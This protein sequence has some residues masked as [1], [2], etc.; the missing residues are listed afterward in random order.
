MKGWRTVSQ[1]VRAWICGAY[2]GLITAISLV[3]AGLFPPSLPQLPGMDKVVHLGMYGVLG[4]LMRWVAAGSLTWERRWALPLAG[5]V[6]GLLLEGAQQALAGSG[7]A[8]SW[9]DA[10]ANLAGVGLGWWGAERRRADAVPGEL[11]AVVVPG[12]AGPE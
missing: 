5:A 9:G 12:R 4:M 2:V 6:Y 11:R 3:P 8:F 1:T 10:A 7:R